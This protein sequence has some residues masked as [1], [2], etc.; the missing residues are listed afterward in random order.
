MSENQSVIQR[1]KSLFARGTKI[2]KGAKLFDS[3]GDNCWGNSIS[4]RMSRD[5]DLVRE[6]GKTQRFHGWK[7]PR[8]ETGDYIQVPMKSGKNFLFEI[9]EHEHC[10]DPPDMFFC[11]GN[12]CSE[13]SSKNLHILQGISGYFGNGC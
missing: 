3:H 5:D 6:V 8:P 9:T 7:S 1:M 2:K 4:W 12:C 10:R 13:A 11:T